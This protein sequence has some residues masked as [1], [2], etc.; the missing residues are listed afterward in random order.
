[1]KVFSQGELYVVGNELLDAQ[2]KV[3]LGYLNKVYTYLIAEK[4]KEEL[5]ELLDRLCTSCKLHYLDEEMVMEEMGFPEIG[6][7]KAQHVRL[8]SHLQNYIGKYDEQNT[9]KNV[10]EL[11]LLKGWFLEHVETFDRKYANFKKHL[12]NALLETSQ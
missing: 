10:D 1:M 2:H 9:A 6:T 12:D 7:H 4:N 11:M 5:F 8:D 3:I